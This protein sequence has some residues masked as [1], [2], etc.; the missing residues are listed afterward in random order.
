MIDLLILILPYMAWF[1]FGAACAF[2]IDR[3]NETIL[4]RIAV[5]LSVVFAKIHEVER[6][7]YTFK[8]IKEKR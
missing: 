5:D 3:Q 1:F 7:I 6:L 2:S 8:E 4:N